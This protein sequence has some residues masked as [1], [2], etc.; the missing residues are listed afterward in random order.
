MHFLDNKFGG[1]RIEDVVLITEQ[2]NEVISSGVPKTL[3][4]IRKAMGKK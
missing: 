4:A 3:D 2:G 1:V